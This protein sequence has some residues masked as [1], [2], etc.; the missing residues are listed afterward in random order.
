M[1]GIL[2]S[3]LCY[4]RTVD[5]LLHQIPFGTFYSPDA[6]IVVSPKYLNWETPSI[7]SYLFLSTKIIGLRL[8]AKV[9]FNLQVTTTASKFKRAFPP[10]C[11]L[12]Y[13]ASSNMGTIQI[14]FF[15][16]MRMI[17]NIF[18]KKY[19]KRRWSSY[20]TVSRCLEQGSSK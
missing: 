8:T 4:L 20:P 13:L 1:R 12:I 18:K 15:A 5:T 11:L 19:A 6:C 10:F 17:Q 9:D 7:F 2:L 3:I 16:G 14:G